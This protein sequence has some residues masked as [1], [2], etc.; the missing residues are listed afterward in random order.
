ML[1]RI[2][3]VNGMIRYGGRIISIFTKKK[4]LP[5]QALIVNPVIFVVSEIEITA[6]TRLAGCVNAGGTVITY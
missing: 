4:L 6:A 1:Y 2:E 3:T 5:V